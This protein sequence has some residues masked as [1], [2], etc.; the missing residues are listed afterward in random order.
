MI[1]VAQE[2]GPG[3]LLNPPDHGEKE[4]AIE[5]GIVSGDKNGIGIEHGI[6]IGVKSGIDAV[7]T[8]AEIKIEIAR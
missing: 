1:A 6:V 3:P 4:I 7:G 5:G 2:I 8:A